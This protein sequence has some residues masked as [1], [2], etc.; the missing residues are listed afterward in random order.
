MTDTP[1]ITQLAAVVADLRTLVVEM[2]QERIIAVAGTTLAFHDALDRLTQ[3]RET[4]ALTRDEQ[5]I[6]R[7]AL[8]RSVWLL[9]DGK[10]PKDFTLS[11]RRMDH[12]L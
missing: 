2:A 1:D 4:V 6:M 11:A 9:A 7:G 3:P 8:R 10:P 5:R 12:S